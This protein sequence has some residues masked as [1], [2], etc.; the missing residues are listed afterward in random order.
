VFSAD[1][2]FFVPSIVNTL[3]CDP[4]AGV[5]DQD[6]VLMDGHVLLFPARFVND[7]TER[8]RNMLYGLAWP[9]P[10]TNLT[11]ACMVQ[12]PKT[13][14]SSTSSTTDA[15]WPRK[16]AHLEFVLLQ[17]ENWFAASL[18]YVRLYFT[19]KVAMRFICLTFS[20]AWNMLQCCL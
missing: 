18:V 15:G 3:I 9:S 12:T 20:V 7:Y 11:R 1:V 5:V 4:Y 13:Y 8:D 17:S 16:R 14:K 2:T 19:L 10:H 6:F